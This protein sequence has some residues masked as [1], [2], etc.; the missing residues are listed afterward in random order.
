MGYLV[1]YAMTF[2]EKSLNSKSG[3]FLLRP[4]VIDDAQALADYFLQMSEKTRQFFGPH[5]LDA[6]YAQKLCQPQV[7]A[8]DSD[9]RLIIT[10]NRLPL[11]VLGYFIVQMPVSKNE[12]DR[13]AGYGISL[14]PDHAVSYAPSMAESLIGQGIGSQV[15]DRIKQT[16]LEK[17]INQVLLMGGVQKRNILAVH[18]YQ[19]FG[20]THVG[21]Y[22]TDV[23]N[24]D[25]ILHLS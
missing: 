11:E 15:F 1:G 13:Y 10:R 19:K 24:L 22:H 3:D 18:Y 7:L 23:E 16:L 4:L 8:K 6:P 21:S 5:P 17:G 2:E 9:L 12:R 14:Q 20:F 25:M